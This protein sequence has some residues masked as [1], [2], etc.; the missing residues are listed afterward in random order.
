MT[1][2]M[3][4]KQDVRQCILDAAGKLIA[5]KGVKSASLSDIAKEVGISKGT[6]Y[7][8][9]TSK[10]DIIYDIADIHLREV[11]EGLFSL[12]EQLGDLAS[13]EEKIMLFFDRIVNAETRGR[14]HLYLIGDAVMGNRSLQE[15][16]EQ[17][18]KEWRETIEAGMKL[19][20][21]DRFV[22][23]D[24]LPHLLLAAVDGFIIQKMIGVKGVPLNHIANYLS[25]P[26]PACK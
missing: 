23:N 6:L 25:A 15:R 22:S 17:K 13:S 11:T 9:Y 24:P 10:E 16:F 5:R 7:Y 8:Y 14:L 4:K 19:I 18:Y 21:K 2:T 3:N 26:P 20:F 1:K 12:F